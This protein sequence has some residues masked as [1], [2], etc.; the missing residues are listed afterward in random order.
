[1]WCVLLKGQRS[2]VRG[3]GSKVKCCTSEIILTFA[4]EALI[5]NVSNKS[6]VNLKHGSFINPATSRTNIDNTRE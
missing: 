2:R 4:T 3:Q 6:K 5:L 1:M